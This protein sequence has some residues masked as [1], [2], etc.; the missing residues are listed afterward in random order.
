M[1]D[2][3]GGTLWL[4]LVR[5]WQRW[6]R[7]RHHRATQ[8]QAKPMAVA[9]IAVREQVVFEAGQFYTLVSPGSGYG[10]VSYILRLRGIRADGR[11]TV[12]DYN[13]P[14]L[15]PVDGMGVAY[16]A[17][18][19]LCSGAG[20]YL[21]LGTLPD[22]TTTEHMEEIAER[23]GAT[24]ADWWRTEQPILVVPYGAGL[25]AHLARVEWGGAETETEIEADG[26]HRGRERC[27]SAAPPGH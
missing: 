24:L 6:Q 2:V 11:M 27:R 18:G 7:L 1:S 3:T 22:T 10:S 16:R 14:A 5:L 19:A 23:V 21:F 17:M 25:T 15:V 8:A 9:V 26:I 13:W 4:G 12:L 20:R